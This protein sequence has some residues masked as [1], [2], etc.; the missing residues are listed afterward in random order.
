[1]PRRRASTLDDLCRGC[2]INAVDPTANAAC[3]CCDLD[4]EWVEQA[5][6]LDGFPPV[7][8]RWDPRRA[9]MRSAPPAISPNARVHHMVLF[10]AKKRIK[11]AVAAHARA[12][13]LRPMTGRVELVAT[14]TVPDAHA[15]DADNFTA[16]LKSPIDG[17][18]GL[19]VLPSDDRH[20]LI[21]RVEFQTIKGERRLLLTLRGRA[22]EGQK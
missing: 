21:L 13:R 20:H 7:D 22:K 12:A 4:G 16:M 19:G 11:L 1:M 5:L 17:L 15:R 14:Y 10:Q 9:R 2:Q 8:R 6:T 18:V 3:L